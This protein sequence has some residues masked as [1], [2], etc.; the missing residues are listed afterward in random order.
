MLFLDNNL[1]QIWI[2][3]DFHIN[4]ISIIYQKFAW[5]VYISIIEISANR[6][7]SCLTLEGAKVKGTLMVIINFKKISFNMHENFWS[8]IIILIIWFSQA[9]YKNRV[10]NDRN[11][12]EIPTL[13]SCE[14]GISAENGWGK[15]KI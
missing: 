6:I 13:L 3:K 1:P 7:I 4:K 2:S 11:F 12:F 15:F 10:E 14:R 5:Y 8:S 9:M